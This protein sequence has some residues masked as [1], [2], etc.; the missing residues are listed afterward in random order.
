MNRFLNVLMKEGSA[1]EIK[2]IPKKVLV[3]YISALQLRKFV[4]KGY[5]LYAFHVLDSIEDKDPLLEDYQS[6]QEFVDVFLDEVCGLRRKGEI[7]LIVSLMLGAT[8]VS[9]APYKMSTKNQ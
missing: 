2:G 7:D 9:K 5:Q 1:S 6:L 3:R 8:L 4:N